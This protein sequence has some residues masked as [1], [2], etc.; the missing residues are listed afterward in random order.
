MNIYQSNIFHTIMK[1]NS[2]KLDDYLF[3]IKEENLTNKEK[4][5]LIKK[6]DK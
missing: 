2:L 3:E 6:L 1:I 4:S 5:E